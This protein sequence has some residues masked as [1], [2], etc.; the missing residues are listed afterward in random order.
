MKKTLFAL[1][2]LAQGVVCASAQKLIVRMDDIGATHSENVAV[3]KCYQEGIGRSAE[4]MPAHGS[5]RLPECA[6]TIPVWT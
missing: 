6:T 1:A 4:I 2:L 5:L 3:I